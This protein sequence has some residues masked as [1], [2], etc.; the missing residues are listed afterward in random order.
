MNDR[1]HL[2]DKI[3]FSSVGLEDRRQ[4]H[5]KPL[6]FQERISFFEMRHIHSKY[7]D[8]INWQDKEERSKV[9]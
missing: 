1:P 5:I 7:K 2:E 8:N 9:K 3:Y 4:H 6:I